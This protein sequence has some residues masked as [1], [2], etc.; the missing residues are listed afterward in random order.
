MVKSAT[1]GKSSKRRKL[2]FRFSLSL[3]AVAMLCLA[4][5]AFAQQDSATVKVSW[6]VLPFQKLRIVGS[7]S[8]GPSVTASYALPQPTDFDLARGYLETESAIELSGASNIP[9]KV[10]VWTE[11]QDMGQSFDGLATKSISDFKLREHGG[12][13]YLTIAREPQ[14]LA[15]GQ[16]GSFEIGVDYLVTLNENGEYRPGN[17][18]L[19]ITYVIMPR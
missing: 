17:Y 16:L 12:G 1:D 6:T 9:W 5:L 2:R 4:I 14:V 11:N 18:G 13:S 8:E 19:E 10:Q 3:L 7:S 15:S